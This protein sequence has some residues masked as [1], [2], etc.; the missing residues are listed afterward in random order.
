[1]EPTNFN[2]NHQQIDRTSRS[3]H[4]PQLPASR[5]VEPRFQT[6]FLHLSFDT[7]TQQQAK[8]SQQK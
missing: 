1:M 7:R 8:D 4:L 2:L 5:P 6:R 3:T